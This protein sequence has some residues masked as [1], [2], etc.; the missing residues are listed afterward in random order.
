[1]GGNADGCNLRLNL[2]KATLEGTIGD[3]EIGLLAHTAD[4]VI[5]CSV[6]GLEQAWRWEPASAEPARPGLPVS[7]KLI[8]DYMVSKSKNIWVRLCR[9]ALIG[10]D[11]HGGLF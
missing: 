2:H 3:L 6:K 9:A 11:S 7:E 4:P 5:S 10:A 1:M 8:D